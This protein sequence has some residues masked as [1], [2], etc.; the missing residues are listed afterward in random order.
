M[1]G[2]R[3]FKKPI[4]DEQHG[5]ARGEREFDAWFIPSILKQSQWQAVRD[6]YLA[7]GHEVLDIEPV[8]GLPDLVFTANAGIVVDGRALVSRF[9]H[10]ER[11]GE[12][13]VFADWFRAQGADL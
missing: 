6:T 12:E 11:T 4:R 7:L 10:A 5:V 13:D 9:R 8:D 3:P 1:R 2:V